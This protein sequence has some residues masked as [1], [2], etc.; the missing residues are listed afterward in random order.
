MHER[1]V[2]SNVSMERLVDVGFVNINVTTL[3]GNEL[4]TDKSRAWIVSHRSYIILILVLTTEHER[5]DRQCSIALPFPHKICK[6]YGYQFLQCRILN[7]LRLQHITFCFMQNSVLERR[8][9]I[10][11]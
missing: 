8:L 3:N 2:V 1:V 5:R 10:Y 7:S 11:I 9:K 4:R 6:I